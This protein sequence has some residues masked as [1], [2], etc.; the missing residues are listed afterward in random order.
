VCDDGATFR[1]IV[2][3]L[4]EG[5]AQ[6]HLPGLETH[7]PDDLFLDGHAG[8]GYGQATFDELERIRDIAILTGLIL[9]PVY[10]NKAFGGLL[11]LIRSG[12]VSEGDRVLFCH[13]GGLF[14]LFPYRTRMPHLMVP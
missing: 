9:D 10:T 4:M 8:E 6:N 13:T 5:M 1:P 7:L 12:A 14:G 11:A 3:A 2:G